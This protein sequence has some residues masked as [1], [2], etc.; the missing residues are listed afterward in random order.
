MKKILALLLML[1]LS[2]ST[3]LA[4]PLP[5]GEM[6]SGTVTWPEEADEVSARYVYRYQ[7]PTIIGE[8]DVSQLINAFYGYLVDD[9][10]AFA[11]P[12]AAE[13]LDENG[14]QAYTNIT[15]EITCN[16]DDWLSVKVTT[17][18]FMGAAVSTI[19]A[20][21]SFARAGGKAGTVVSLPYLLGMLAADETDTWLQERQTAKADT[22]VRRLIW[23]I[24]Q[25]QL[26]DG[27]VAYYDDL[28]FDVLEA[29]FYPEEDFYLDENGNPVFFLQE[30]LV[31]PATEGILC[32]PFTMEELL[33]E[34]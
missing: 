34:L 4:E 23:E 30:A 27:A 10:L 22:L 2:I 3:A 15:S 28:T 16:N 33:D 11:V 31:A 6:L 8:D 20:G 7:Y 32:F 25:E 17:E 14:P 18:S 29:N 19:V 12:M 9:A 21:H 13:L 24:M 1:M 26:A 5:L